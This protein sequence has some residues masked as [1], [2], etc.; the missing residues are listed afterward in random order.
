MSRSNQDGISESNTASLLA[1]AIFRIPN[2]IKKEN[3]Q[4]EQAQ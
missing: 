2:N 3:N 1:E 4:N